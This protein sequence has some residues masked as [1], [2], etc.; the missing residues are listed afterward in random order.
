MNILFLTIGPMESIEDRGIYSDL[1]RHFRN[2]GHQI[3]TASPYEK[4]TG[5]S[6]HLVDENGAKML[7]IS[8]GNITQCG[9]IEKGL[10]TISIENK[11]LHAIKKYFNGV[12]FDLV[13]YSTPPI[14][15][16]KVIK[17][18]KK[19]DNAKAYLMLKDI[20]PQ[21]AVDLG[22]LSKTGLK[23]LIYRYFRNKEKTLYSIS[24]Y[25]GC[26][27]PANVEYLSKHNSEIPRDKIGLCP[28]AVDIQDVRL[29]DTGRAKIREKYNIPQDKKVFVYGGNLGRPQTVSFIVKCLK[30]CADINDVFFV[31]AG[32]GTDRCILEHYLEEEKPSHVKLFG[33]LS[34]ED[35]D[36]MIA[37]CDFGLIFLDY[38]FTIPNFPSRLLSYMQAGLP[39]LAC[40]DANTDIGSIVV[41]GGFG[42]WCE[43]DREENFVKTVLEAKC[44]DVSNKRVCAYEFLKENYSAEKVYNIIMNS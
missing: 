18:I 3:Y 2:D 41:N 12:K 44:D 14:T 9:I 19:R 35:Y 30:A 42:W 29:D 31:V 27:S 17:Y 13:L 10:S 7:H 6:T 34:K 5:K 22:M 16:A 21:N 38:R 32:D 1:L 25:I 26:M 23:G 4:K 33:Y 15:F 11:F 37:C 40:T 39:V 36:R 8:T 28:N 43:S 24:D 20:F